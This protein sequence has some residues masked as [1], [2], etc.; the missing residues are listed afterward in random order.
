MLAVVHTDSCCFTL[1]GWGRA[2][3]P[4]RTTMTFRYHADRG[5]IAHSADTPALPPPV[6]FHGK[7]IGEGR[8]LPRPE[9]AFGVI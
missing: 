4:G 7:S 6:T 2:T 8:A 5:Q 9:S 3:A 1:T